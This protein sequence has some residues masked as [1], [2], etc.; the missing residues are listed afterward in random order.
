MQQNFKI[1]WSA[2]PIR[3]S[4]TQVKTF[5]LLTFVH[6]IWTAATMQ[7]HAQTAAYPAMAPLDQY[8]MP[9]NDE[10]ALVR[11]GARSGQE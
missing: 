10:I 5:L 2:R 9:E 11:S 7:V 4:S 1:H 6:P 8:L 3:D